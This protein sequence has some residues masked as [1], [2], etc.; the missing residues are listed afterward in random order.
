MAA[1]IPRRLRLHD[2]L[3][4]GVESNCDYLAQRFE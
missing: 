4:A 3:Q 2:L 1:Q